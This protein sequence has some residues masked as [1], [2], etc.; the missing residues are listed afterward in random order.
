MPI[1]LLLMEFFLLS[2]NSPKPLFNQNI[3]ERRFESGGHQSI[4]SHGKSSYKSLKLKSNANKIVTENK[5]S[6]CNI[7][8]FN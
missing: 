6:G 1:H 7:N 3:T 4:G 8:Y 5:K 2:K